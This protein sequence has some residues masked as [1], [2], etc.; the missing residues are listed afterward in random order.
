MK[1]TEC[2]TLE[3][4]PLSDKLVKDPLGRAV[5]LHEHT[6]VGHIVKGHPE[7]Q[8]QRGYAEIAITDRWRSGKAIRM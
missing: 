6:W 3:R 2:L 5:T 7:M 8:G 4:A 1:S